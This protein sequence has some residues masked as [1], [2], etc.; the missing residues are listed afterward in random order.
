[1]HFLLNQLVDLAIFFVMA[2]SATESCTNTA[3]LHARVI[4]SVNCE[5][6]I[7]RGLVNFTV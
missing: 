5:Y 6:L 4:M 3:A 7:I 1:M 2:A